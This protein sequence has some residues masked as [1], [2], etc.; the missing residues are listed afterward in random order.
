MLNGKQKRYLRSL[1]NGLKPVFQVGKEG[2]TDNLYESIYLNLQANELVKVSLLKT[3]EVDVNEAAIEICAHTASELVQ[4]I[5]RTLI[6]YKASKDKKI[7][8]P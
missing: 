8:L 1:A 4:T 5:G 3:C 6:F 7:I 2:L